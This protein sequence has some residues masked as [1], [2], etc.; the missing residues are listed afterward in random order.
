MAGYTGVLT[1]E[2]EI[3]IYA[4][5]SVGAADTEPN[6]NLLVAQAEEFLNLIGQYDFVT[7]VATLT[8]LGKQVLSEYCARFVAIGLIL[9]DTTG[10]LNTLI[11]AEDMVTFHNYR[12]QVIE[13]LISNQNYVKKLNGL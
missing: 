1:T 12:M 4:G 11:E 6:R 13:K 8:A 3:A 9:N 5:A 10:Y 7:N 2:A